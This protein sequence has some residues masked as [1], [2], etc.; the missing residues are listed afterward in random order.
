MANRDTFWHRLLESAVAIILA[1]G[2]SITVVILAA[3]KLFEDG[4]VTQEEVTL[5]S[6]AIGGMIGAVAT[7]LGLH[8]RYGNGNGRVP[9][10]PPELSETPPSPPSSPPEA[11]EHDPFG[12]GSSSS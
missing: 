7:Y 1:L 8:E 12:P 3:R 4:A 9:T 10:R 2:V 5:L 11:E 6:T